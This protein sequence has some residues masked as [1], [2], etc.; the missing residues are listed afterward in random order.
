[1]EEVIA[2]LNAAFLSADRDLSTSP[3]G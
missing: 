3:T 1:M 2:E